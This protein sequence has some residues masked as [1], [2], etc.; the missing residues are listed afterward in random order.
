MKLFYWEFG[1]FYWVFCAHK[2]FY[3]STKSCSREANES[4]GLTLGRMHMM[5]MN[6]LISISY[7][8]STFSDFYIYILYMQQF[9][10][11][12]YFV[13]LNC[14][15]FQKSVENW[16]KNHKKTYRFNLV[17]FG[18]PVVCSSGLWQQRTAV[19][20][21]EGR[22]LLGLQGRP[23]SRQSEHVPGRHPLRA[24]EF[25]HRRPVSRHEPAAAALPIYGGR[26]V[27]LWRKL[28]VSPR[29]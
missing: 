10:T 13:S 3:A 7:H 25:G 20:W 5:T 18:C 21:R 11:R 26:A 24:G 28:H 17:L 2:I 16:I 29:W 23:C 4:K 6:I 1:T 12:V 9:L 8:Q 14:K 19:Q 15:N 27:S 22:G